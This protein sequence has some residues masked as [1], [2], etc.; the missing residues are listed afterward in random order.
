LKARSCEATLFVTIANLIRWILLSGYPRPLALAQR[1]QNM[2]GNI[3]CALSPIV[4][5]PAG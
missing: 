3:S 4:F 2:A 1:P 5:R